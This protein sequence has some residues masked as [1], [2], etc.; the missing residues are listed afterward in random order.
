MLFNVRDFSKCVLGLVGCSNLHSVFPQA[1]WARKLTWFGAK[2]L[3][4]LKFLGQTE[5]QRIF[6]FSKNRATTLQ[7][8][9]R[10][11]GALYQAQN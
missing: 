9:V 5:F 4:S 3:Q 7:R 6:G 2:R 8:L 1:R 10:A 11:L